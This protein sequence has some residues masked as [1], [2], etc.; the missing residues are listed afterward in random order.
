MIPPT[1]TVVRPAAGGLAAEPADAPDAAALTALAGPVLAAIDGGAVPAGACRLVRLDLPPFADVTA[2][3][4]WL[5]VNPRNRC[6]LA[7]P[8]EIVG[9]GLRLWHD[10][11][12]LLALAPGDEVWVCP[13]GDAG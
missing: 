11:A 4:P 10:R 7:A 3:R 8:V 13:V 6:A 12:R 5:V 9:S 2:Q 1:P